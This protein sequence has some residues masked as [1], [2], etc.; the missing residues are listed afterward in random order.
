[1]TQ[2]KITGVRKNA[3]DTITHALIEGNSRATSIKTLVG[4]ADKEL[5]AD[6]NSVHSKKSASHIRAN[7]DGKTKNNLANL[8]KI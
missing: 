5:I 2:R 8:P 3:K 7:P 6:V 4:M 1:M